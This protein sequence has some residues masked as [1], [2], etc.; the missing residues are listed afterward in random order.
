M[1]TRT[2]QII[3]HT[4]AEVVLNNTSIQDRPEFIALMAE[5]GNDWFGTFESFD[6]RGSGWQEPSPLRERTG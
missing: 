5:P 4:N 1:I 3:A 6:G 2:G